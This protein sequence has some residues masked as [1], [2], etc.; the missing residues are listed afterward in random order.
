MPEEM[1]LDPDMVYNVNGI[2]RTAVQHSAI[3]VYSPTEVTIDITKQLQPGKKPLYPGKFTVRPA[4]IRVQKVQWKPVPGRPDREDLILENNCTDGGFWF[5]PPGDD[6]DCS[7]ITALK[8]V[9]RITSKHAVR[10][11]KKLRPPSYKSHLVWNRQDRIVSEQSLMGS[12]LI[13]SKALDHLSSR[14]LRTVRRRVRR[15]KRRGRIATGEAVVAE[16][17]LG[18]G[19]M[20]VDPPS[21][22]ALV[23]LT[24]SES[25]VAGCQVRDA[26]S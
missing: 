23:N 10:T 1:R 18:I 3:A 4:K 11:E 19:D 25:Q 16:P 9:K 17:E 26:V 14:V 2:G 8:D 15:Q 6:Y 7:K 21:S 12:G 24:P 13:S 5:F 22:A 20:D